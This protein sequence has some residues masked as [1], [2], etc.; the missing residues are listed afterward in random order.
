MADDGLAGARSFGEAIDHVESI[1]DFAVQRGIARAVKRAPGIDGQA[2]VLVPAAILADDVLGVLQ[3][4]LFAETTE[5]IV[6]LEGQ[7]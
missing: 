6:H 5:V 7:T 4:F 2:L 1:A 3:D